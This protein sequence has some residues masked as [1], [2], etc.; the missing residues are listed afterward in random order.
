MTV[1]ARGPCYGGESRI[2]L[3][4]SMGAGG[5]GSCWWRLAMMLFSS[6]LYKRPVR[7]PLGFYLNATLDL[8]PEMVRFSTIKHV[9]S[10]TCENSLLFTVQYGR[11]RGHVA[12]LDYEPPRPCDQID[13]CLAPGLS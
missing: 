11:L 4:Q 7:S 3:C 13:D 5:V 10:Q 6:L 2:S 9:N 8:N 1:C 12:G